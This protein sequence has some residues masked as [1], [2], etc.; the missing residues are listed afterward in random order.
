MAIINKST[1]NKSWRG[2]GESGRTLYTIGG[3]ADWCSHCGKQYGDNLKKI[4]MD[5]SFNPVTPLL[6]IYPKEPK[7]LI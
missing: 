1:N 2:C 4:K 3:K 6:G 7:A 5:L